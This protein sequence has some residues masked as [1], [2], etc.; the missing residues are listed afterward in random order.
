M[1]YKSYVD[2]LVYVS[3][4]AM[5][6]P[7]CSEPAGRSKFIPAEA[8]QCPPVTASVPPGT[9]DHLDEDEEVRLAEESAGYRPLVA[10]KDLPPDMVG[11]PQGAFLWS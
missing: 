6:L 5:R 9:E 2:S 8:H 10:G 7:N 4:A 3:R 11:V 1:V